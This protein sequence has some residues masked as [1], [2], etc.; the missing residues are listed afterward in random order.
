MPEHD[1]TTAKEH[2]YESYKHRKNECCHNRLILEDSIKIT[3]IR[4][5][6][7]KTDEG[8]SYEWCNCY[9]TVGL[10]AEVIAIRS[11]STPNLQ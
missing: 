7:W 4:I 6:E 9:T 8:W 5:M 10:K 3:K 1:Q 2:F 11:H